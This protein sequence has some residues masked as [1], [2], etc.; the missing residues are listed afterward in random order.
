MKVIQISHQG[1]AVT[2]PV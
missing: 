1:K 2:F